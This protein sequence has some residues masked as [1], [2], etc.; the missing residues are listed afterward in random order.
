MCIRRRARAAAGS[1]AVLAAV[2]VAVP[3]ARAQASAERGARLAADGMVR[4]AAGDGRVRV[5]TWARDSVWARADFQGSSGAVEL[6][7]DSHLAKLSIQR[8]D[9]GAAMPPIDVE[10]RV[11]QRSS[12]WVMGREAD[13]DV[14]GVTGAVEVSTGGGPVR[15]DGA[16]RSVHAETI[17]G[18][19]ELDL[20]SCPRVVAKS[21]TGW[22]VMR[23][24]VADAE[25]SSVSGRLIT[26]GDHFHR[27]RLTTVTGG[28]RFVGALA[29]GGSL[30]I[31]THSGAVRLRVP[32]DVSAD[33]DLTSVNGTIENQ[34]GR[35]RAS[36]GEGGRGA[37][38][39]LT[40]GRGGA[41]VTVNTF[42]G[43]IELWS[44]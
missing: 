24:D 36:P 5:T 20:A 38:L 6:V 10:V 25:L 13:V 28:V 22:I 44:P 8:T 18:N 23:G 39:R 4:I 30:E 40:A 15:V 41:V 34:L 1:V 16:P 37:R 19:V 33:F 14:S 9:T 17:D 32:P 35:A 42:K 21:A 43:R 29:A 26:G 3:G 11:P 7:G 31:A 12:V 27:G 2:A